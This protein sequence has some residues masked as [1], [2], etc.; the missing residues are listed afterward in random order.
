VLRL[1]CSFCVGVFY[2]LFWVL[3]FWCGC[4]VVIICGCFVLFCIATLVG[5]G[6]G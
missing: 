2:C 3:L 4:L 6:Y 5:V 1:F